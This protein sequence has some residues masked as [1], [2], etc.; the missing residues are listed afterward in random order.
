MTAY[1][2]QYASLF[3]NGQNVHLIGISNDPPE[4]MASWAKD[5]DF[6]FLFATDVQGQTYS[7]FG[8]ALRSNDSPGS[9]TVIV[10]DPEGRIAHVVP[11]F[12]QVDPGAYDE[13][14]AV[15]DRITPEPEGEP[16]PMP[17]PLEEVVPTC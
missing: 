15:I 11:A 4:E 1:R 16:A 9:R 8:G 2:D 3:K 12:N 17:A 5:A 6:P 13:L 7:S 10:V 14:G